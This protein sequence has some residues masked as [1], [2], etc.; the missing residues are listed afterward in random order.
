M[1]LHFSS[2]LLA[3]RG[4]EFFRIK[5]EPLHCSISR[6]SRLQASSLE[7]GLDRWNLLQI[8][9][10]FC[11]RVTFILLFIELVCACA[12]EG[13][14]ARKIHRNSQE[15]DKDDGPAAYWLKR[16]Q[17]PGG[18]A[19]CRLILL[20]VL[21]VFSASLDLPASAFTDPL[22]G[23]Y[24]SMIHLELFIASRGYL[25]LASIGVISLSGCKG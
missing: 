10:D 4:F 12:F 15:T 21:A 14:D 9:A 18:M 2:L 19:I 3:D 1:F 5:F 13:P 8:F 7:E 6:S 16:T 17:F 11:S 22:D 23:T 20:L 24:Y 25:A